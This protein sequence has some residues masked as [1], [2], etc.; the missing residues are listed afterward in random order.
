M[1]IL[2]CT[3]NKE[4]EILDLFSRTLGKQKIGSFTTEALERFLRSQDYKPSTFHDRAK[5]LKNLFKMAAQKEYLE[6]SP[7]A[8]VRLPKLPELIPKAI[9][10][11]VVEKLFKHMS[12]R[13]LA[14]YKLLYYTGLRPS[15]A[16]R[17]K[18]SEIDLKQGR[19]LIP[20]S[21][22]NRFRVV[23]I[24]KN[25]K[26][27]LRPLMHNEFLFPGTT[28]GH[29][30]SMKSGLDRA[31]REAKLTKHGVSR[32]AFRHT[33]ATQVLSKTGGNI[34]AV[35]T[36]LGHSRITMTERYAHVLDEQLKESVA[37]L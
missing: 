13:I 36:L 25:L 21:K 11:E 33:F 23:P 2:K 16:I 28:N 24:H 29:Q 5:V 34:R 1:S 12:G 4:K 37:L 32:Y 35:Q 8:K 15:E 18:S 10:P 31:I 22:S 30:K 26:P 14:Y 6:E 7:A 20:K 19:I 17:L 27:F 9:S 3:I